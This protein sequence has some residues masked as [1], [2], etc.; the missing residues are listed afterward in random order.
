MISR[1]Q[2][3][4]S[5]HALAGPSRR[6]TSA[7]TSS[8]FSVINLKSGRTERALRVF[9]DLAGRASPAVVKVSVEQE[10]VLP[11]GMEEKV[12]FVSKGSRV[13][14]GFLAEVCDAWEAAAA[15]ATGGDTRVA[16]LRTGIVLSTEGGAL[17]KQL[18]LFKAFLGGKMGSGDQWQS[19][20]HI[21]DEVGHSAPF[22]HL[23]LMASGKIGPRKQQRGREADVF[24]SER[25]V[26]VFRDVTSRDRGGALAKR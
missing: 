7:A 21:D 3:F 15:P 13:G 18:P 9:R 22:L 25:F 16:Y 1:L 10:L 19:W 26:L 23:P 8:A 11:E 17:K 14:T 2:S 12:E 6:T 5:N 4:A 24:G 20:I